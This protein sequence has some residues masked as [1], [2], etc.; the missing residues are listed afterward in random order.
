MIVVDAS[1]LTEGLAGDGVPAS[2]ARARLSVDT[3][4]AAPD[5]LIAEVYS[6]VRGLRR[7]GRITPDRADDALDA[8]AGLTFTLVPTADLLA[9]MRRL[10]DAVGAYDAGYVATARGL[11]CALVTTDARLARGAARWCAVDSP[12]VA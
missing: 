9:A 7:G 3:D 6:A 8:L 1:V 10:G 11:G 12:A 5:Y 2:W 4:W